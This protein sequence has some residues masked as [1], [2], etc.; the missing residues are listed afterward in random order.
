MTDVNQL[1][2]EHLDIWTSATEKKSSAG[3]GNGGAVSLYGVKKLRA[4]ILELA[5]RG[6]LVPPDDID[7]PSLSYVNE[8]ARVKNELVRHGKAKKFKKLPDVSTNE[9]SYGLPDNWTW[10]RLQ[11]VATYIQRGKSPK[12]ADEG[13]VQTVSQ[14]C[15]QWGRFDLEKARYVSNESLDAYGPE[16]FLRSGDI[17]WNSTGTGTVGRVLAISVD[18]DEQLVADSHV[19]VIRT[20]SGCP[21]FVETFLSSAGIQDRFESGH[22]RSL[23]SGSTNQVELNTSTVLALPVPLPPLEEQHRIV[24]KVDELMVLCDALEAQAED[25][26]KAHQIL[27]ETSL[28]TLT[29][30]QSTED[31]TQNWTRLET[32]FDTLFTTE[33]SVL[34]LKRTIL[35]LGLRGLLEQQ[36]PTSEPA[37]ARMMRIQSWR[38]EAVANK[39]IRAPKKTLVEIELGELPKIQPKGWAWTRLGNIIYIKSGDGLT[40][41]NM[42]EGNIPVFGGN[43]ITGW[44]DNAN[45][46]RPTIVIGRVGYYCGSVHVTPEKA[47]VTDNAFET[48]FDQSEIS[49]DFLALLLT[50]T[51][52]KENENATAQPVISGSKIYPIVIGLPPVEEQLRIVDKVSALFMLCESLLSAFPR[53]TE[54]A[55]Q[56]ADTLTSKIH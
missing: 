2:T 34:S 8:I 28:A 49:L 3:R 42:K 51:D 26:L 56:L 29:N 6:K 55:R 45:I 10:L 4:L 37:S 30:S 36:A 50:G 18:H 24:A 13:R 7:E 33:T 39:E 17:L 12:Y 44:H 31:L 52:L 14:K 19:T 1:I 43:G 22:E 38:E 40:S 5:V 11:D 35:E 16:R 32:H 23:V 41:K 20:I 54:K 15:V 53:K 46:N 9:I 48:F 21:R 25:S 27:V 47:W